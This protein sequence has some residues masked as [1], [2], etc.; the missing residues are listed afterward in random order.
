M[1]NTK[2]SALTAD[3]APT[4]DD[5]VVTVNDPGGTPATRKATVTNFT[6]AI[7][8]VIGDS[9]SGGTKGLVPAPGAGDAAANKFLHADGTFKAPAGSGAIGGSSGSTDNA[10]I[11]ADGTG[12]ATIQSSNLTIPDDAATTEVGYLNI[13]QN[14]QS[15]DYTLV[16]ADRGKHIYHP[17]SDDNPR[18]F[19]IPANGSVAYAIGTA[20]TFINDQNTVTIAITTDTL[21]WAEDGSTGSRVLAENGMATAIKVTS[22]RWII[23]GTG[24]S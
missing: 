13:P 15:S 22:T 19:T 1:A 11:R 7:P 23:S 6:K 5:L 9:G 14:S 24:L 4:A 2:I 10:A 3:T 12:G 17:T 21:V 16:I 20:I 8:A 18:T